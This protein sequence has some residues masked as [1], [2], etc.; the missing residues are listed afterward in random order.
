MRTGNII[1]LMIPMLAAGNSTIFCAP[2]NF[3]MAASKDIS[4]L[5]EEIDRGRNRGGIAVDPQCVKQAIRLLRAVDS[6]DLS[7]FTRHPQMNSSSISDFDP[8]SRSYSEQ[9]SIIMDDF[10]RRTLGARSPRSVSVG[11][12]NQKNRAVESKKKVASHV[13]TRPRPH[14][15]RDSLLTPEVYSEDARITASLVRDHLHSTSRSIEGLFPAD[16]YSLVDIFEI[17]VSLDCPGVS[18]DDLDQLLLNLSIE[19]Y[20]EQGYFSNVSQKSLIEFFS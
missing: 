8:R 2:I 11:S 6:A 16:S 14:V 10:N 18:E 1:K 15:Q 4:Q 20:W 7:D 17:L 12:S 5:I 19:P 3:M 13:Q 9:R